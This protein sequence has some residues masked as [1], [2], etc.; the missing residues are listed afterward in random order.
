MLDFSCHLILTID[1]IVCPSEGDLTAKRKLGYESYIV[2]STHIT[3]KFYFLVSIFLRMTKSRNLLS[4]NLFQ[5]KKVKT[6]GEDQQVAS[7]QT[8]N[9][10]E[11]P[12]SSDVP[13]YIS[14]Q[15]IS[16]RVIER[17]I[18][19]IPQP[20][21]C[22]YIFIC[23]NTRQINE[24]E[25]SQKLENHRGSQAII[26]EHRCD[27]DMDTEDDMDLIRTTTTEYN[28]GMHLKPMDSFSV[29]TG[30]DMSIRSQSSLKKIGFDHANKQQKEHKKA[31]LKGKLIWI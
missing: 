23:T 18:P 9:T 3:H 30:E 16:S 29:L 1:Y 22:N 4:F 12:S 11:E 2:W 20:P 21:P 14:M 24:K 25:S 15:Q 28:L 6:N 17:S 8:Q 7:G 19:T 5:R 10:C 31:S 27:V 13:K 26:S